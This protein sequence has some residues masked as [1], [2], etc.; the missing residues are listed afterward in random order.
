MSRDGKKRVYRTKGFWLGEIE[1]FR[2]SGVSL[3]DYCR[4]RNLAT[5][6]FSR[7]L[8]VLGDETP[9]HTTPGYQPTSQQPAF[10]EVRTNST[11]ALKLNLPTGISIEVP[12]S[13]DI[14][15]LGQ[16]ITLCNGRS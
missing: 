8:Q 1:R 12:E 16:I 13:F 9:S 11:S 4:D 15:R 14:I 6:T 3:S 10:I 5:S 7:K 2:G